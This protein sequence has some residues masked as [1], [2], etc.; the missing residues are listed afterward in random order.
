MSKKANQPPTAADVSA[1]FQENDATNYQAK[2]ILECGQR[3][4]T[5]PFERVVTNP[6]LLACHHRFC[7][8]C[9]RRRAQNWASTLR[10]VIDRELTFA[11]K[12]NPRIFL[13]W[14][15]ITLPGVPCAAP[16]LRNQLQTL[17]EQLSVAS[18]QWFWRNNVRTVLRF[19]R[20]SLT[21]TSGGKPQ[22]TPSFTFV[23][24]ASQHLIDLQTRGQLIQRIKW[25]WIQPSDPDN[26]AGVKS[27]VI[28]TA[29]IR[30]R[31]ALQSKVSR[32]L[33]TYCPYTDDQ[34]F[35]GIIEQLRGV[36]TMAVY[37]PQRN[38]FLPL[39]ISQVDDLRYEREYSVS[40][41]GEDLPESLSGNRDVELL[42]FYCLPRRHQH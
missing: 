3:E 16:T 14:M 41:I 31:D 2:M 5:Y 10:L 22:V 1:Y 4:K 34:T 11:S 13:N 29:T 35:L 30:A 27:W 17:L 37:G 9:Q 25:D 26:W 7:P 15:A 38:L 12:S 18:E 19:L 8:N 6:H 24:G 32:M 23:M 20:L 28:P 21:Q 33:A 36:K 42:P 40:R 39:R